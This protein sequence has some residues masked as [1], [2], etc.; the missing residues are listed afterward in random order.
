MGRAGVIWFAFAP[1]LRRCGRMRAVVFAV[2][3]AACAYLFPMRD[4]GCPDTQCAVSAPCTRP[5]L[6]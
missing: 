5:A 1:L 4:T 2:V 6:V 3:F